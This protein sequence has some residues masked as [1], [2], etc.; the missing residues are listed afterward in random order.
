MA[1]AETPPTTRRG[2]KT[3]PTGN[4]AIGDWTNKTVA[5]TGAGGFIGSHL[6]ERLIGEGAHVR[7]LVRYNSEGRRGWLDQIE[8]ADAVEVHPG[9][10]RDGDFLRTL[11]AGADVVFHLAA[12]IGIPYSSAA[13]VSYV[14]TNVEGTLNLLVAARAGEVGRVV[15]TSTSEVYGS[16]LSA[17]MDEAHPF[18]AQSPYAASKIGADMIASSF[19]LSFGAPVAILRPFNTY[20]PRQSARAVVPTIVTQIIDGGTVRLG[21]LLPT[22]DLNFV[23]DTVD[24]F[25]AMGAAPEAVGETINLGSGREIAIGELAALI[26][27]LMGRDPEI[28]S[29]DDRTRPRASEVDRLVCDNEKARRLLG[30]HPRH[31]LEQG[32]EQTIA[33]IADNAERY[34]IGEY[35]V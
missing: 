32:L 23:A 10:I 29:A 25:L 26:G 1:S 16:A 12:L 27:R 6:V 31:T 15:H 22:R 4:S 7:A 13:P 2:V 19:H 34:R 17:P 14:Q 21:N 35:S 20:G 5:V 11:V 24:G 30:W 33:W 9:D 18:Q 28:V 8:G 3:W